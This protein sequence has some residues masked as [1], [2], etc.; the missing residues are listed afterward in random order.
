MIAFQFGRHLHLKIKGRDS[1]HLLVSFFVISVPFTITLALKTVS[2][3]AVRPGSIGDTIFIDI[4]LCLFFML[5]LR[6]SFAKGEFSYKGNEWSAVITLLIL[7]S[8]INPFNFSAFATLV[9]ASFVFTHILFFKILGARLKQEILIRGFLD[10]LLVLS[11]LQF[12]LAICFPVLGI[13]E[14]TRLFSTVAEEWSTRRGTRSGAVGVF[15]HPGNLSL[16]MMISSSFFLGCFLKGYR[17]RLAILVLLLNSITLILTYSRT[18]YLAYIFDLSVIYFIY[19][20]SDRAIFSLKNIFK[21]VLP[22]SLILG[23]V[24]F[25]SPLSSNFLESDVDEMFD[26]RLIHWSMAARVFTESPII[27]VGLN[28][29]LEYFAN[30]GSL[31]GNLIPT[32]FYTEN[33]I[34]N[35]HLI[36]LS[37]TGIVGSIFWLLFLFSS[38]SKAKNQLASRNNEILSMTQIGIVV[39]FATYGMTGWAPFSRGLLPFLLFITFFSIKYRDKP[40]A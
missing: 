22:I 38:I 4:P 21:F 25:F 39:A 11:L 32:D 37:E 17:K 34:H 3:Q 29:H 24:V 19:S 2:F 27:G 6:Q 10:G 12:I 15:S 13:T 30:N 40:T 26:A 16:F 9:F 28:S 5:F 36:V 33:P 20:N 1:K 23:W 35:I 8:L 7:I 31:I 14:V 18:A